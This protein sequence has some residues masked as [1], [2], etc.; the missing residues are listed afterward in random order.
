MIRV[1]FA[2]FLQ[3]IINCLLS[4]RLDLSISSSGIFFQIAQSK[5]ESHSE[6]KKFMPDE[7]S[8]ASNQVK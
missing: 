6:C 1:F 7:Y 5:P 3:K 4:A 2:C 8:I